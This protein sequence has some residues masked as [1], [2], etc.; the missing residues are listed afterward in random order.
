MVSSLRWWGRSRC[1]LE[2]GRGRA[3]SSRVT[4]RAGTTA[5]TVLAVL[6]PIPSLGRLALVLPGRY[7]PGGAAASREGGT[8]RGTFNGPGGARWNTH[9]VA[10]A[11]P[12]L[13]AR[14]GEDA[15]L[16]SPSRDAP[17]RGASLACR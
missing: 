11:G 9:A 1:V 6:M 5:T 3:T 16:D 13:R 12:R 2:G 7:E 15:T 10:G 14:L 8:G 17:P 4:T